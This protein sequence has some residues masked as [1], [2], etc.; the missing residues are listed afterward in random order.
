MA[1]GQAKPVPTTTTTT[2]TITTTTTPAT[3]TTT[4]TRRRAVMWTA[5]FHQVKR[6]FL[7][8]NST[9]HEDLCFQAL[10]GLQRPFEGLQWTRKN[11]RE[12]F[13]SFRGPLQ[14]FSGFS[15]GRISKTYVFRA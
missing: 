7:E 15:K 8:L 3:T 12:P 14:I 2:T 5:Q 9:W 6:M 10:A 11:L 1:R 13:E 4:N